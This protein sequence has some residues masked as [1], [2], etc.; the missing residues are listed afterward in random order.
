MNSLQRI[1]TEYSENEDRICLKGEDASGQT[2]VLW[3]TQRLLNQLILHLCHWLEQQSG[4]TSKQTAQ[5]A[6]QDHIGQEMVQSFAQQA[7][8]AALVPQS[9][10][11]ASQAGV[12]ALIQSVDITH[13]LDALYLTFKSADAGTAAQAQT[14]VQLILSPVAL[15]QWLGIVYAQHRKAQWPMQLWPQWMEEENHPQAAH[16]KGSGVMWH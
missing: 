3:L 11:Q 4:L 15:R 16:I 6:N 7:A 5:S 10:V 1:T 2:V 8:T 13:T 9:P 12:M 14:Q